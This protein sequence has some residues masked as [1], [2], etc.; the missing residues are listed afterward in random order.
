VP[1]APRDGLLRSLAV[2]SA[3][4]PIANAERARHRVVWVLTAACPSRCTYC[5]IASQRAHR[6]LSAEAVER[7]CAE[8]VAQG[9]GE[10]IFVGGEPLLSP[11][12]P[13]ALRALAGRCSVAVFTGGLP[14]PHDRYVETLGGGRV[15]RVVLSIDSGRDAVN[16]VVRGRSGVTAELVGLAEAIRRAHPRIGLSV[17]TVVSRHNV[18]TLDDVFAR[19]RS[20]RLD[21]WSLTLA[22]DNFQGSPEDALVP[23]AALATH[24]FETVPR[25][26]RSLAA[27]R[28][29]LVVLP[30]PL[31]LLIARVPKAAWGEARA[32][33][34]DALDRELDRYAVGDYNRSFVERCG[35]P[36]VGVDVTIGVGGEVYPC[37]QAPALRP[38][39]VVGD[40]R[41]ADLGAILEGASLSAFRAGVPHAPCARCWAPSNVERGRLERLLGALGPEAVR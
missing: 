28:V 26:A 22:G 12:L 20:L 30:V 3:P 1:W 5:D 10:V 40:L 9:F 18:A 39:Y 29:E 25:L 2:R 27:E 35:C 34:G 14:A 37:S 4:L 16:D 8:I 38:E 13:V 6:P 33:F 17:N 19:L 11:E 41:S 36:L 24:Y 15:E 7:A 21:S 32:R 23:R 31:P